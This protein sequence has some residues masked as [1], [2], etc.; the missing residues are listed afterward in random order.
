M[1]RAAVAKGTLKPER[2]AAYLALDE[3]IKK[4][5]EQRKQRGLIVERRNKLNRQDKSRE[6]VQFGGE[7]DDEYKLAGQ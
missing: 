3:Q 2:L 7:R 6:W 1:V 5:G 4:L